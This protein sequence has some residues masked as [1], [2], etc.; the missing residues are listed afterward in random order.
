MK[1]LV[2]CCDGTG[3]QVSEDI[4]NVLKFYRTLRK[5]DKAGPLQLI[6]YDPGIGT[7]ALPDPW[8]R[9]RQDAINALSLAT[10]YGLND[11]VLAAYRFLITHYE[12]GDD[13]YLFGFSRGAYTVRVLAALLHRIG[14]LSPQQQNLADA[15]LNAYQRSPEIIYPTSTAVDGS[16]VI[17]FGSERR[18]D[19]ASQFS[20]IVS[21]R[22]PTIRFLGVWDTVASIIVPRQSSG[23]PSVQEL[24]HTRR[25]PS[26]QVFRQAI[27]LDEFRRMFR[28]H[29]W[30]EGQVHMHNRFSATNNAFP[31]D[32]KQVWFAGCHG[33]VGGG[34]PEASSFLSKFPLLWMIGEAREHGL[35][36]YTQAINQLAWGVQ[37]E[38]SPFSYVA[39]KWNEPVH[40]SLTAPW[41]ILEYL[42][43]SERY[44][45]F[46]ER[47]S[48]AGYYIPQGEPRVVPEG[49]WL[50]ESVILRAASSGTKSSVALPT[51]YQVVPQPIGPGVGEAQSER[52]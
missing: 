28:L 50:H 6:Y 7:L 19:R 38:G 13:I 43:K 24:P 17:M 14:V 45:E 39:P 12:E 21:V 48:V 31:Q 2:V 5:T 22:W 8:T 11:L 52:A 46:K 30:D 23:L 27:A 16:S 15:A 20:R 10:G 49:S 42:P 36:F 34:Y 26:V 9:F 51:D 35:N 4:S 33:D 40:V 37:R 32:S 41:Q 25:N 3:N 1:K 29:S 47:R 44:K 18:D